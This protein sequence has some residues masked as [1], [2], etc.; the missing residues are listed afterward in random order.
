MKLASSAL[1]LANSWFWCI[2]GFFPVLL[3]LDF[4]DAAFPVF[5]AFNVLGAAAF[6]LVWSNA[7]RRAFLRR[8]Q[9]AAGVFSCVVVVFHA[10]FIVWASL[11]LGSVWPIWL[12]LSAAAATVALR[13][14]RSAV[15]VALC[16][17]TVG[18]FVLAL[19]GPVERLEAAGGEAPFL[20]QIAPLALGFLLAP[21]FDLTFHRVYNETQRPGLTFSVGFGA[22]FALYLGG[23]YLAT[24]I[25]ATLAQGEP[26]EAVNL[27]IAAIILQAA[28]TTALHVEESGEALDRRAGRTGFAMVGGLAVI[29]SLMIA[30]GL[31]PSAAFDG[32]AFVY[33]VFVFLI[34]G[35]FPVVLLFGGLN[36]WSLS[37]LIW[38]SPC[39]T[40]GFLIGGAWVPFLTLAI[41]G[42][43]V[44]LVVQRLVPFAMRSHEASQ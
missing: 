37:A 2:G 6:G 30:I 15:S 34:G 9:A 31:T 23:M 36:R 22:L 35:V 27:I 14:Q 26:A 32:G 39:Y 10:L 5:A 18:L 16:L 8:M 12:W 21:Y 24:P 29:M 17:L 42:L 20:H 7:Q 38:I 41:V 4:G 25:L 1:Y 44:L 13:R 3:F 11:L 43:A 19:L 28:F 40:L 33:R